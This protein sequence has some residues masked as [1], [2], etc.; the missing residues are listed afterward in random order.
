MRAA[1]GSRDEGQPV[2][3]SR[4]WLPKSRGGPGPRRGLGG[5]ASGR[6]LSSRVRGAGGTG[7]HHL[8]SP[9]GVATYDPSARLGRCPNPAGEMISPAPLG[10]AGFVCAVPKLFA[11]RANET[12]GVQRDRVPLACHGV[13]P[14]RRAGR[15]RTRVWG[16]QPQGSFC[17]EAGR[18]SA[19]VSTGG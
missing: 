13:V 12:P 11:N 6:A 10:Q 3:M 18:E 7:A 9:C 4:A 2:A 16:E 1:C 19:P 17:F 14:P 5:R 8:P 15:S